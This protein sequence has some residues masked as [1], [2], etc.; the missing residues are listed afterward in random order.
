M[1]CWC[2]ADLKLDFARASHAGRV[3]QPLLKLVP[4]PHGQQDILSNNVNTFGSGWFWLLQLPPRLPMKSFY[5]V[6]EVPEWA[7][8]AEIRSAYLRLAREYHPDRVPEHLTKLRIDA[9]EQF[10]RVQEAWTVLSDPVKRR[11]YDF[12]A[13]SEV[14][15]AEA[16]PFSSRQ[17]ATPKAPPPDAFRGKKDLAKLAA[18]VAIATAVCLVVA[19]VLITRET[20]THPVSR[21][22]DVATK[23]SLALG[24]RQYNPSPRH[25]QTWPLGGGSGLDVQL[26]SVT[27]E[28]DGLELSFRVRCCESGDLLLYE[29]PGAKDR[30]RNIFGKQITVDRDFEEIY[31]QDDTGA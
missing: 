11:Q 12:K 10:K 27:V 14:P 4:T 8:A 22:S 30:T 13:Q 7:S 17:P 31:I 26:L 3:L 29:P 24:L 21:A 28:P 9:E 1:Y 20:T 18:I 5:E 19:G 6:L 25:I 2:H 16:P 15:R 23:G